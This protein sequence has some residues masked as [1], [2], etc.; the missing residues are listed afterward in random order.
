VSS[1]DIPGGASGVTVADDGNRSSRYVYLAAGVAGVWV[2]NVSDVAS[3]RL[4]GLANTPARAQDIAVAD[5]L[6]YVAD[7]EG[8]LLVLRVAVVK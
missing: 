1:L 7:G 5:D 3:A 6:V 2:A 8:G 4:A